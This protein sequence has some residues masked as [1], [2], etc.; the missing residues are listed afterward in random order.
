MFGMKY[1]ANFFESAEPWSLM[2]QVAGAATGFALGLFS[3]FALVGLGLIVFWIW[4][5]VAAIRER[6]ESKAIWIALLLVGGWIAALIFYFAVYRDLK[7]SGAPSAMS[8]SESNL[9]Q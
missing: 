5:L 2:A 3:F 1:A 6:Y 7:K 9:H 8:S 4:M